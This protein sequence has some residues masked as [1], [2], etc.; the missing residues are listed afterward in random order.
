ML[1]RLSKRSMHDL[2]LSQWKGQI[3]NSRLSMGQSFAAQIPLFINMKNHSV[4]RFGHNAVFRI[5]LHQIPID[6]EFCRNSTSACRASQSVRRQFSSSMKLPSSTRNQSSQRNLSILSRGKFQSP[7]SILRQVQAWKTH[8][9]SSFSLINYISNCHKMSTS[10]GEFIILQSHTTS[11]ERRA[12]S[13]APPPFF[14]F[15]PW[16]V[17]D[18]LLQ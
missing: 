8:S 2:S 7:G 15:S 4:N 14:H 6:I 10:S 17:N 5:M 11:Q 16:Q 9:S 1:K 13:I 18:R 3:T 12:K